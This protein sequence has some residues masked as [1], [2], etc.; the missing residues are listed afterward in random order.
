MAAAFSLP[1]DQRPTV[2]FYDTSNPQAAAQAY[3]QAA[4][5]GAAVIIGPLTKDSVASVKTLGS[6]S[7]PTVAL[8]HTSDAFAPT[9]PGLFQF[10][11]SPEEE[12]R[13]VADRAFRDGL[14]DAAILVP[15]SGWGARYSEG[16]QQQWEG[17]GGLPATVTEYNPE[18][19]HLAE[20]IKS[21]YANNPGFFYAIGKPLKSRQL[22]TQVQYFG[23][24]KIPVFLTGQ[25]VQSINRRDNLDLDGTRIPAMPWVLPG[26]GQTSQEAPSQEETETGDTPTSS[27]PSEPTFTSSGDP[28]QAVRA[29]AIQAGEGYGAFFAMG[30]DAVQIALNLPS[31]S[32]GYGV[33]EGATGRLT[34]D[35]TGVVH[36]EPTWITF[37]N[38]QAVLLDGN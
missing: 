4:G 37:K 20:P 35:A 23:S 3:T 8:N 36:R 25:S 19:H 10:A 1:S 26:P 27:P 11:L 29:G 2:R 28:L 34:A 38:G 16:F 15:S 14:L 6:L 30:Y 18:E 17:L 21:A 31:L 12:G 7:V 5:E 32:S 13:Q 9:V 22:R 24:A 33:I